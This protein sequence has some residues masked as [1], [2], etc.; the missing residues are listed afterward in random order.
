MTQS[1]GRFLIRFGEI[2]IS[3][4]LRLPS[5]WRLLL[6][7][8]GLML[9]GIFASLIWLTWSLARAYPLAWYQERRAAQLR[10]QLTRL[11]EQN[12]VLAGEASQMD[13]LAIRTAARFGLA[14]NGNGDSTAT[15]PVPLLDR[16]FPENTPS[17]TLAREMQSLDH[18]LTGRIVLWERARDAE[19]RCIQTWAGTPS[20]L[21]TRGRYSSPFGYRTNPV[22]GLYRPHLGIDLSNRTGTPVLATAD[23]TVLEQQMSSSYGNYILL[24]HRNGI[25]TRYAHLSAAKVKAGRTVHRGDLIGLMG[26]TGRSTGSH[27]HYEVLVG[28]TAVNPLAWILPLSISP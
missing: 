22:T 15:M 18:R 8:S 14:W 2:G 6:V 12:T 7:L 11:Q 3:H 19:Q 10:N 9:A 1:G 13:S 26:S 21:P 5:R 23:G 27:L 24:R 16:M 4:E 17:L 20:V 28:G 25:C